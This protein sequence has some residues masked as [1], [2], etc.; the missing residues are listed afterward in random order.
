MLFLSHMATL[1]EKE[2]VSDDARRDYERSIKDKKEK[3]RGKLATVFDT[4]SSI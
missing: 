4:T 3:K 2:R 1:E